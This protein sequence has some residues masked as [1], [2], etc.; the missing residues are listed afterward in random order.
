M[1]KKITT[2]KIA[3][4]GV[5]GALSAVLLIFNFPV[6]F[7]PSFYKID[8]ADVPALIGGFALGP[9]TAG[10]IEII[11]I[12]LNIIMEGGSQT[13]FIGELSNLLMSIAF[14]VSASFVYKK[15]HTKKGAIKSLII[16]TVVLAIVGTVLNYVLIIPAYTKFMNIPLEAIIGMGSKIIPIIDS[17]LKLVLLC[18]LPFNLVKGLLQSLITFILYKRISP[19]LKKTAN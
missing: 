9:L 7:A 14:V 2:K 18:T 19:L 3:I 8:F 12:L 15:N 16:G 6:F 11:K 5:F 1:E 10:L 4:I 17:K 13:A